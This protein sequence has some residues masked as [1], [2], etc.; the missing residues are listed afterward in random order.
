MCLMFLTIYHFV[1]AIFYFFAYPKFV[2]FDI[3]YGFSFKLIFNSPDS[4]N[5]SLPY[6]MFHVRLICCA[7][8]DVLIFAERVDSPQHVYIYIH[9]VPVCYINIVHL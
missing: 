9:V 8:I 6:L 7:V 5:D 3:F 2:A 4:V 1:I